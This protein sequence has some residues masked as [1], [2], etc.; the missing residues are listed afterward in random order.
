MIEFIELEHTAK[1]LLLR[2]ERRPEPRHS[3]EQAAEAYREFKHSLG[4]AQIAPD[5][6]VAAAGLGERRV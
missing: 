1:N 3:G 2:A 6:I 5:R 4:L